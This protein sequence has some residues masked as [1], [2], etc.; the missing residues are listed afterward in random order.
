MA[1]IKRQPPP[2]QPEKKH[3]LLYNLLWAW[4]WAL[5]GMLLASLLLSLVIEYI[6]I[7][8]F[9]P[10]LGSKHSETVMSTEL[11]WL[12]R[13]FTRSLLLSDPAVTVTGWI[14]TAYQWAF[15]DSGLLAWIQQSSHDGNAFS[16]QLEQWHVGLANYLHDYL[17]ATIWVTVIV[18]V[19]V[20]ILVL[21]L[22]LFVM[23]VVVALVEGLGRRDLRRY[24]AG[25]ESSF[26]Y[27]RAKKMVKSAFAIPIILYLSWPTAI[28]PNLIL[29]PGALLLGMAIM[30]TTA[31]FKKYL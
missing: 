10:E 12:S 18:L 26:V 6:G 1:E 15:V 4:P 29:L 27:H 16:R 31:S 13:E 28:Y 24:G 9:W 30:V 17:M 20:T 8:F 21:S 19:R 5:L 11:G 14:T 7:A 23:A 25:Y 2:P 22:P 3:G